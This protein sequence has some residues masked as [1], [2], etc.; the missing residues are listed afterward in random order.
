MV[1]TSA[2]SNPEKT[3]LERPSPA[4]QGGRGR[5]LVIGLVLLGLAA[6]ATGI[7]FQWN[8]TRKC[9]AFYGADAARLITTAPRVE[10]VTFAAERSPGRLAAESRRDISTARGLVHLRRGLVE[11]ANFDWRRGAVNAGERLP[12]AAWDMALVFSDPA[13]AGATTSLVID[14]DDRG[15]SLAVVGR[16]GRVGLGRIERGLRKWVNGLESP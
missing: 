16:P 13:V 6:A 2:V 7:W 12:A 3:A 15:G 9:L 4:R 5:S 8:Q 11:D 14:F 10:F 1:R